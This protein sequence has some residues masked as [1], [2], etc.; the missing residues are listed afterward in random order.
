MENKNHPIETLA[1]LLEYNITELVAGEIVL[2]DQLPHWIEMAGSFPLKAVL[3]RYHEFI[4]QHLQKLELF[5]ADKETQP[6]E[7]GVITRSFVK[8]INDTLEYCNRK[9]VADAALLAGIQ[10]ISHFKI[11]GYG[12]VASFAKELALETFA[13]DFFEMEINEKHIDDRLSQLALYDINR[14]AGKHGAICYK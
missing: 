7:A 3:N 11:S 5:L 6:G 1:D 9:E 8:Y 10:G 2:R 13:N 14:N 4:H 12:T